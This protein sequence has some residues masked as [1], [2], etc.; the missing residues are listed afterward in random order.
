MMLCLFRSFTVFLVFTLAACASLPDITTNEAHSQLVITNVTAIDAINGVRKNVD[1]LIDGEQISALGQG[2]SA[3]AKS[4]AKR[5]DGTGK[6]LIPG[7]WDAH[8]HL[9]YHPDI[10]HEVFFPLSLAHGITYLRDTGGHLDKLAE[11][12]AISDSDAIAP[13]L[14][15][16]GPLVD[17]KKRVYA[18][19]TAGTP[20]LS[21]GVAN[22]AQAIAQVDKL[23]AQGVDFVKAYEMLSPAALKAVITRAKHHK[24]PVTGHS[25]LSM[26]VRQSIEAGMTD[27]QHLR[28]LEM[29]CA[30]DP[31]GLLAERQAI[32]AANKEEFGGGLRSS[33][34]RLQREK[35]V[36]AKDETVCNELIALMKQKGVSQTPTLVISRFL[37]RQLYAD[38]RFQ[39]TFALMPKP[40]VESWMERANR[41]AKREPTARDIAFDDWLMGMVAALD[42]EGV[43]ILAGTDAPIGFLTPG[44]SLHEELAMLV[45]AGLTPLEVIGSA[46][47]EPAVFLGIQDQQGTIE[48]ARKADLVMLSADPLVDIANVSAID[49]VIKSGRYLD[50]QAL[51]ELRERPS[52]ID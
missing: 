25:P 2:L 31:D 35:A 24:L 50:K 6:Y 21:V 36:A 51:D 38:K 4:S 32:I 3:S 12:R 15:V 37:S 5:I 10:G 19:Q 33:L 48:P 27:M 43:S 23:A 1:I 9:A 46:T 11:A 41:L 17:G 29:D 7:L 18:G 30:A 52:K 8:V 39:D 26:T 42:R 34:H 22:E 45:E 16:S 44:A 20:D 13:D 14:Y 40:I 28:N 47:I 49:A